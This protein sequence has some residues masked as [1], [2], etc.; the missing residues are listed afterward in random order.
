MLGLS[1]GEGIPMQWVVAD[2]TYG[3]SPRLRNFIH[4]Q[5][6]YYVMEV[7]QTMRVRL[8]AGK[9]PQAVSEL[10]TMLEAQQWQ[11]LAFGFGEKGLNFYD[12]V[13]IRVIPTTDDVG[14]K[15]LLLRRHMEPAK[16]L[17]ICRMRQF[18]RR[19][20]RWPRLPANAGVS[21]A[22]WTKPKARLGWRTTK[23]A[24]GR[25]GIDTPPCR[26]SLTPS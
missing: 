13:A 7:S 23:Y 10:M 16:S 5:H 11:R 26:W 19:W 14:E 8:A 6:R 1:W 17:I 25:H 24:I 2:S 21:S 20:K 18:R 22:Y 4:A 12:W 15:W 3:N 9:P